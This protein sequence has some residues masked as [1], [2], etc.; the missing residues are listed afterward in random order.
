M[1]HKVNARRYYVLLLPC[2]HFPFFCVSSFKSPSSSHFFLSR[3][4]ATAKPA[5]RERTNERILI[6]FSAFIS[7]SS[8]SCVLCV[9]E[10]RK[11][12]VAKIHADRQQLHDDEAETW[13]ITLEGESNTQGKKLLSLS[14]LSTVLSS[15]FI[16]G[17]QK[18]KK[19]E[20]EAL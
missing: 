10:I 13:K 16:V 12:K 9:V 3:A 20:R 8:S 2:N 4:V 7:S 6:F 5:G 17:A 15:V 11:V 18:R 14:S 19:R 1:W